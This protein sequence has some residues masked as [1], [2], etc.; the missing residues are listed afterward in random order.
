M[1]SPQHLMSTNQTDTSPPPDS[2]VLSGE[3]SRASADVRRRATKAAAGF[4]ALGTE[5]G[6]TIDLLLRNDFTFFEASLAATLAGAYPVPINWH[7]TAEEAGYV[8]RDCG[9]KVLIVHEDLLSRIEAALPAELAV[10]VGATPIEIRDAYRIESWPTPIRLVLDW[11]V[12]LEQQSELEVVASET[13]S[14]VIYTSGTT[15]QPKG[16]RRAPAA[17]PSGPPAALAVFGFADPGRKVVLM[18][19]PM[20]HSAPNAYGLMAFQTGADIVLQA[21]FDA[22][23]MLALIARHRITHMHIV[24]T[25]FVRLLK[26]PQE[27]RARYDLSS[28]QHVVHGAA[29]CPPEIKRQMIEWWGPVI[30]EYYGSTETGL[31]AWHNS[32][33]ALRKPGTVGRALPNVEIKVFTDDGR[34]VGV[35]EIGEIYVRTRDLPDFTYIGLD[36]KRRDIGRGEF[37]TVGDIGFLDEE[38]FLFLCDRKRDMIISGGVNIY[39]AEIETVLVT[40]AGVQDCAVFGIPDDE[41]G[42]AICAYVQPMDGIELDIGSIRIELA[43]HISRFKIPKIIEISEQL[44]R[45]DSGKIFK[46]KLREP[47]WDERSHAGARVY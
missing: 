44:P 36:D 1:T 40:L 6:D 47:Y 25:M 45:E 23:D 10:F 43:K 22:E 30:F 21:R 28:L 4:R 35:G 34:E 5:D 18:N 37:V 17:A 41:F 11:D 13:R 27:I 15:G 12:W 2:T 26:L 31:A 46:R 19:G 39:P 29:P 7:S 16:V 32:A 3:R 14:A 42:E 24:P 8:L 20:Y 9:A 38:G 33:V